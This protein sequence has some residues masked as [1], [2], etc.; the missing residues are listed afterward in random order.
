MRS[1][2]SRISGLFGRLSKSPSLSASSKSLILLRYNP[3]QK[4]DSV[5]ASRHTDRGVCA[6]LRSLS[7]SVRRRG[8]VF[9]FRKAVPVDLIDRLG[10][11]DIRRSLR[12]CNLRVAKQR[13]W[14][15]ILLIE[16]AFAE[17][18]AAGFTPGA[19]AALDAIL[20]Q[21]MDDFDRDEKQW[22]QRLFPY[23]GRR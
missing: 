4:S 14:S 15:L 16:D 17:L 1:K 18:R 10:R 13:A 3:N 21:M 23:S 22:S 7:C 2:K 6:L 8:P 12:T 9:W 20:N 5:T 11:S 19:R